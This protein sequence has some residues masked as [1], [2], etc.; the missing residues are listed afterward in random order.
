MGLTVQEAASRLDVSEREV[1]RLIGVGA[2]RAERFANV[3][4]V[5]VD[6]V[7]QRSLHRPRRGRPWAP[8]VAWAA[9]WHLSGLEA[10]WL[11]PND[12]SR[13][14]R[15]LRHTD[16]ESLLRSTRAR[17]RTEL[18]QVL[19]VYLDRLIATEG[20]V[21]SGLSAVEEVGADLLSA[22]VGEI[23]CDAKVVTRLAKR[24]GI[25][26]AGGAGNLILHVPAAD[27]PQ[28]LTGR[29]V[30]PPA[31]VAVDLLASTDTRT[32]RAGRELAGRLKE[33]M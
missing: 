18:C 29:T 9:L 7:H 17:A 4:M 28:L 13:L 31:V 14:R 12:L 30:M 16:P 33:N 25:T 11:H 6:G 23:Y 20:V 26:P 27:G 2:L 22:G 1:R 24:Y 19:P 32:R 10:N 21:R 15:R 8:H 5:D 3:W